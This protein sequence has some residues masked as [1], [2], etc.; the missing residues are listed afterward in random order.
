MGNVA[1]RRVRGR[2]VP[3]K[4]GN[5]PQYT[6][7]TAKGVATAA[8]GAAIAAYSGHRAH[9][10]LIRAAE[11]ERRA[12]N[13]QSI[14]SKGPGQMGLFKQVRHAG[15]GKLFKLSSKLHNAR[16][17]AL[18]AGGVAG[19]ALIAYGAHKVLKDQPKL[20]EHDAIEKA[21]SVTGG[22]A[23]AHTIGA[24]VYRKKINPLESIKKVLEYAKAR[25]SLQMAF[26]KV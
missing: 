20:K 15:P 18:V 26:R 16:N 5:T 21:A 11:A 17:I 25:K 2:I 8:T 6:H 23:I 14:V 3:I 12:K 4:T 10:F 13:L 22:F 9:D 24:A 19:G 1:F 7:E